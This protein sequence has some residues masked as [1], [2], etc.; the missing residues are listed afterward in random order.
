MGMLVDAKKSI[1]KKKEQAVVDEV[2]RRLESAV[3]LKE[4]G[5]EAEGDMVVND[6]IE[7]LDGIIQKIEKSTAPVE[8][9]VVERSSL[10]QAGEKIA[11]GDKVAL[12]VIREEEKEKYLEVSYEYS[13]MKGAYKDEKFREITWKEFLSDSSFVC[14]IYD[15]ESGDY[16]GYCSVKNLVKGDWELAIELKPEACHKGYGTEALQLLMQA[17]NRLTDRR[18]FRVRVEIDNHASQG[19]MKKIGAIP[20]GI[21]EFLLHGEEIENFQEDYKDMITDEIREVAAEFCMEAEEMLGYVLE[22]RLDV[23]RLK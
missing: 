19:L 12:A 9:P 10:P 5:K 4:Q 11:V 16:V 7:W 1:S 15:K 8:Q 23:E 6:M 2:I 20:N 14:S 21:S 13:Y 18:Y 3:H 17:L 22:Y